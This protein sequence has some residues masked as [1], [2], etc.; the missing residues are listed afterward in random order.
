MKFKTYER[1]KKP[2]YKLI[3]KCGILCVVPNQK[4]KKLLKWKLKKVN[5]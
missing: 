4:P 5:K 1:P 3:R 2:R